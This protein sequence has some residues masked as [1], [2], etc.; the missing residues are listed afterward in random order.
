MVALRTGWRTFGKGSEWLVRTARAG[1]KRLVTVQYLVEA[2]KTFEK[3][4]GTRRTHFRDARQGFRIG[5][6]AQNRRLGGR[7]G[8]SRRGA[9]D[10][11]SFL[12]S[13][14]G[15]RPA[16]GSEARRTANSG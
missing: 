16:P 6:I 12:M 7:W 9:H 13:L 15:D 8:R 11:R 2:R 4:R 14:S 10:L 1:A 3:A 5:V